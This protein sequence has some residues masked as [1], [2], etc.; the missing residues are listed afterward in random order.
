VADDQDIMD[1]IYTAL[2]GDYTVGAWAN[3]ANV[4]A[5]QR[6][7]HLNT[8]GGTNFTQSLWFDIGGAQ[9]GW[10]ARAEDADGTVLIIGEA[11]ASGGVGQWDHVVMRVSDQT[12]DLFINGGLL[13]SDSSVSFD[14]GQPAE[15]R[16]LLFGASD[17]TPST[18]S[19]EY[20]GLM[21]DITI[22]NRA[23][24]NA[25]IRVLYSPATRWGLYQRLID[26]L[27][28]PEVAAPAGGRIMSSLAGAGG[29]AAKGGIA[30]AGGGLAG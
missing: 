28:L 18:A 19:H 21:S 10:A 11:I 7:V 13:G 3:I 26:V 15:T 27:V 22:H 12:L 5:D 20:E 8:E 24:S 6:L 23:L 29:L 1:T 14:Q 2:S 4:T 30:G 25:E 16:V 17:D 9:D